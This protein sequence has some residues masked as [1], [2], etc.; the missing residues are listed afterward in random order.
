MDLVNIVPKES[1]FKLKIKNDKGEEYDKSFHMRSINLNDEIWLQKEYGT[2]IGKVFE[3]VNTKEISRI[4]FRLME[5]EDKLFFAKRDIITVDEDGNKQELTIGGLKL[6][7]YMISGWEEK[8]AVLNALLE[9]I[10]LSRPDEKDDSE[11]D[12]EEKKSQ[13]S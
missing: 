8:I 2:A 10:G 5:D 7:R 6:L 13:A 1:S 3:E 11:S 4:V 12:G 9:N